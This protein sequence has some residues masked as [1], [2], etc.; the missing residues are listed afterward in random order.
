MFTKIL[1]PTDFSSSADAAIALARE[2]FPNAA[3]RLLHVLDPKRV[4]D[5]LAGAA[6]VR[7]ERE[8]LASELAARL[9]E[10][11][12]DGDERV[13]EVGAPVEVILADA[14]AWRA[15]LIVMG[16]HGRTGLAHF[17]NGSVAER[18]VRRARRPVLIAH[19]PS[20]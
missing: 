7:A 19:D 14:E 8:A 12:R 1:V 9:D 10:V 13:V 4:A 6:P 20:D 11:A 15:D 2:N 17:L 5:P 16:T 3:C 18:V